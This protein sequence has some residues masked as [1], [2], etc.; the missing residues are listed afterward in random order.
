MRRSKHDWP[1]LV[2][3]QARSGQSI[4]AFCRARGVS[5]SNFYMA[6]SRMRKS[7]GLIP[8]HIDSPGEETIGIALQ[9]GRSTIELRAS[10]AAFASVLKAL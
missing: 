3:A 7:S 6:R 1:T 10:A 2:N 4:E 5:V 8:I 9:L